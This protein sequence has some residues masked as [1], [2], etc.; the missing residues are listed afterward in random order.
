M[1]DAKGQAERAERLDLRMPEHVKA[2]IRKAAA[3][4]GRQMS[5]FV[6]SAAL[7]QAE[8]IEQAVERWTLD[9]RDSRF[10]ISLLQPRERPRLRALMQLS[11]A[12]EKARA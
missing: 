4:S 11:A 3:L 12:Q 2:R 6:V 7:A 10:V 5:D 9:E 1:K 8:A